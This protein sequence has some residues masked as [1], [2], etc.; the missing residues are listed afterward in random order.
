MHQTPYLS[1]VGALMYLATT[2]HPHIT[3]TVGVLARFNSNP[4]WTHWLAVKHLLCYIKGTLNYSITYSPDPLQ[5]ETFI[6][7]SD[8]VKSGS[9][10]DKVQMKSG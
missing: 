4:G 2:T 10:P 3:Y 5:P 1:A 9:T 6:M 7:F 8:A